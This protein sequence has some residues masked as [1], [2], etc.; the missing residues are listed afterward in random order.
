MATFGGS[1]QFENYSAC[2]ENA[3]DPPVVVDEVGY[4]YGRFSVAEAFG[5][6][7]SVCASL[8]RFA[9]E[10]ACNAVKFVC[11]YDTAGACDDDCD[12]EYQSKMEDCDTQYRDNPEDADDLAT[13][14]ND[15]KDTHETCS[16]NCAT[17]GD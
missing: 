13:C 2:S 9:N 1:R 14:I 12:S 5:H 8:G 3:H 16:N 15:S 7:D 4:Y 11:K 17:H 6:V 10:P